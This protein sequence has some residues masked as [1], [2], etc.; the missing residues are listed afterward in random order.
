MFL[1]SILFCFLFC[2][3][4]FV[5]P[6]YKTSGDTRFEYLVKF[7]GL[8]Y[9]DCR[10]EFPDDID[11]DQVIKNFRRRCLLPSN[12]WETKIRPYPRLYKAMEV[13]KY[14]N[15]NLLHPWQVEGVNWLTFNWYNRRGTIL[16]DE[17]GLGK[18]VQVVA[19][20]LRITKEYSRGP[21][22][23]VAP[24]SSLYLYSFYTTIH[25]TSFLSSSISVFLCFLNLK[26]LKKTLIFMHVFCL[27][28]QP[29]LLFVVC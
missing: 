8:N 12:A 26:S 4:F 14:K 1:F 20:L 22:L 6:G 24:L 7:E 25:V 27:T 18:T 15:D 19:T 2:F 29:R 9:K 28:L 3:L 5:R 11:D 16:A 21:F 17:M 23:I 10:W 13:N